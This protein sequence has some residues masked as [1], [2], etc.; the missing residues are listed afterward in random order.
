MTEEV[1]GQPSTDICHGCLSVI[2]Q[3]A[4]CYMIH[5]HLYCWACYKNSVTIKKTKMV[6]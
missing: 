4:D 6:A 2:P 1:H 3:E 5:G